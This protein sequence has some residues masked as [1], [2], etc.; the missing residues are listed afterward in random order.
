VSESGAFWARSLETYARP[1]MKAALL[2]LQDRFFLSVNLLL[3]ALWAAE[4]RR[5]LSDAHWR[6]AIEIIAPWSDGVTGRLRAARRACAG[7]RADIAA[8]RDKILA[9]EIDAEH[10]E[11]DALERFALAVLEAAPDAG[12]RERARRNLAAYARAAGAGKVPGFSVAL[13]ERLVEI[14]FGRDETPN[15]EA[16]AH[17][18]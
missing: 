9:A 10:A 5:E 1:G 17:E 8:L 13:L 4:S 6:R 7:E 11:Q 14:R 12:A 16:P 3:L 15:G 18:H 2:E